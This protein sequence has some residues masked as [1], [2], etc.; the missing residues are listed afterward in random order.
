MNRFSALYREDENRTVPVEVLNGYTDVD[1]VELK[2]LQDIN[3]R[4]CLQASA[5]S[6][7][8]AHTRLLLITSQGKSLISAG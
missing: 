8:S 7:C 1:S 4:I 6:P 2:F 5:C 3:P